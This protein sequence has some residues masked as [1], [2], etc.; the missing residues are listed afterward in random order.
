MNLREIEDKL[1]WNINELGSGA[2]ISFLN[3]FSYLMNR[4][5]PTFRK[6]D[7]LGIDGIL[8]AVLFRFFFKR[9]IA[10]RA[11][12]QTSIAPI[13]YQHA[14]EKAN[15]VYFIG[16]TEKNIVN[17]MEIIRK[18]YAKLNILGFRNGYFNSKAEYLDALDE[19][20]NL[21]PN[22]VIVGMGSP[23]Q[24]DF[25]IS[26]K[27]KN[28]QGIAITCGGYI[29][30]TAKGINY[31]PEI[32]NKLHLRW[33]YRIYDEPKLFI[34]YALYY[35]KAILVLFVDFINYKFLK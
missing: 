10:R 30:Q 25:I 18:E 23:F 24:E 22:Y 12:D 5:N 3:P 4:K 8:L 11:F 7:Y 29:H 19:I 14:I 15:S 26:L 13:L 32:Y 1:D 31:F 16:S 28:Y 34:R 2:T 21:A 17:F 20:I 9:S 27:D 33:L 6:I 35:P